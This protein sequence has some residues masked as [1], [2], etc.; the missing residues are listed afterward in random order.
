[1]DIKTRGQEIVAETKSAGKW[2][3]PAE[4]YVLK[5]KKLHYFESSKKE[6]PGFNL[7][8][9]SAPVEGLEPFERVLNKGT[10]FEESLNMTGQY[11]ETTFYI[12]E[13][14]MVLDATWAVLNRFCHMADVLGLREQFDDANDNASTPKEI[15]EAWS[16]V[17]EG[18]KAAF[19]IRGEEQEMTDGDIITRPEMSTMGADFIAPADEIGRLKTIVE[20]AKQRNSGAFIKKLQVVEAP[21]VPQTEDW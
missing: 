13:K 20:E 1:M 15:V 17:F 10:E 14:T 9:E 3:T 21:T 11:C 7:I 16:K 5:I 18:Q 4:A 12:T 19:I 6:T 8:L 2:L